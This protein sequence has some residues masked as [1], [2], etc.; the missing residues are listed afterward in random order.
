MGRF[1]GPPLRAVFAELLATDEATLIEAAAQHF[2]AR[3]GT[4]G[5]YDHDV[6]GAKAHA[7]TAI[8][9][10]WGYGTRAELEAAGADR[11]VERLEELPAAVRSLCSGSR[12]GV[13]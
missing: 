9:V 1:I 2:R 8:G 6:D 5:L 4:L 10:T 12:G 11:V 13:E 3:F 7:L